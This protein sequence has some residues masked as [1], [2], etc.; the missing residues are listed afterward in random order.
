MSYISDSVNWTMQWEGTVAWMY[1]D[2]LGNVTVGCG[3]M[4]PKA[5][6]ACRLPFQNATGAAT[7]AE[8]T[9]DFER[10]AAMTPDEL[11]DFYKAD[12]SP[13]LPLASITS[14]LQIRVGDND[15]EL[16]VSVAGWDQF[17]YSAKLAMLDMEYNLGLSGLI[18]GYPKMM[19]YVL[20]A[21]WKMAATECARNG[22]SDARNQWTA[23]LFIQAAPPSS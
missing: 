10:V 17:P 2:S 22:V 20:A 18:N 8:I 21:N 19:A 3:E 15:Q 4:L 7:Q 11:P 5:D 13:I 9:A 6:A 16:R 14:M 12:S 1:L 23:N